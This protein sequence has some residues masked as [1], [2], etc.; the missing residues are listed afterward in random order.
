MVEA[1]DVAAAIGVDAS[2]IV[3]QPVVCGTGL[4][5]VLAE[6]TDLA[7]LQQC[8]FNHATCRL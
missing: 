3:G 7:A 8:S 6:L 4:P 2:Q 5:F 1:A